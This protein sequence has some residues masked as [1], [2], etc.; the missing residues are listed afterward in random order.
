[1]NNN[2]LETPHIQ[3]NEQLLWQIFVVY[4]VH[5][6]TM[7]NNNDDLDDPYPND[8]LGGNGNGNGTPGGGGGTPR[9]VALA[10]AAA[11]AASSHAT[12]PKTLIT[13]AMLKG[14]SHPYLSPKLP[15]RIYP[16]Y[17]SNAYQ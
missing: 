6:A 16:R 3:A 5:G 12:D 15:S 17:S 7:I 1:M 4:A 9:K 8:G 13:A 10:L 11:A 2:V 14:K